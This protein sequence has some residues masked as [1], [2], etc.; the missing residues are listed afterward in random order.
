MGSL[1]ELPFLLLDRALQAATWGAQVAFGWPA[2]CNCFS[3]R[4][5]FQ[6]AALAQVPVSLSLQ[7][8]LHVRFS[9]P[10]SNTGV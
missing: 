10:A 1:H 5:Q 8:C 4:G 7:A 3:P 9:A 6:Y 2:P